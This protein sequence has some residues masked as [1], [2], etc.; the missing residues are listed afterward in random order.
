[1]TT[2]EEQDDFIKPRTWASKFACAVSGLV[3]SVRGQ[4]SFPVYCVA[5]VAVVAAGFWL[6]VS[7]A[8][9][10]VLVLCIGF[11]FTAEIF[12]GAIW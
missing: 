9:W 8:E 12:N 7:L 1:M 5:T 2:P 6:G 4:N 10:G 11:V 3:Q